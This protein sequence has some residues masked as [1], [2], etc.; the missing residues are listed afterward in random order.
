LDVDVQG[1]NWS[2]RSQRPKP[3]PQLIQFR[4]TARTIFEQTLRHSFSTSVRSI[5][6]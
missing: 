3:R 6:G 2:A 4:I 1:R 5:R